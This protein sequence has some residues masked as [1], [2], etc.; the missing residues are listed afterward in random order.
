MVERSETLASKF[1]ASLRVPPFVDTQVHMAGKVFNHS[2]PTICLFFFT[3][4][5]ILK[6]KIL[7]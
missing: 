6:S 5:K 2:R 7:V 1:S 4:K 3:Y